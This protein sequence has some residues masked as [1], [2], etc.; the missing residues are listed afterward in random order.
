MRC[1]GRLVLEREETALVRFRLPGTQELEVVEGLNTVE[2]EPLEPSLPKV[3]LWL[4]LEL[5]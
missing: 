5:R 4:Y 2:N 3:K 1:G